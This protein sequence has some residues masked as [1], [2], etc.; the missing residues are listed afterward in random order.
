MDGGRLF[1]DFTEEFLSGLFKN[2]VALKVTK[3]WITNDARHDRDQKWLN[4]LIK[5]R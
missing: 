2:L 3:M 4:A 5:N 1:M